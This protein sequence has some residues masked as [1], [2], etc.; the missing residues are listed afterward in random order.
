MRIAR[1]ITCVVVHDT[2]PEGGE[3]IRVE[4]VEVTLP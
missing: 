2:V 3:G 1:E 4:L